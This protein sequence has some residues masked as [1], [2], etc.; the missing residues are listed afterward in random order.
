MNDEAP[1]YDNTPVIPGTRYRV[2]DRTRPQPLVVDPPAPGTQRESGTHPSDAT[3]LFDGTDLSP[4]EGANGEAPQWKVE[5]GYMEVVPGTGN[6]RTRQ[7]FGDGQWHIE[8]A[9]PSEIESQSQGRGN[10]G[11]FLMG[12]YEVQVLDSYENP[13]YADGSAGAI[14]GQTPPLVNACRKP[15]E[16][17][18]FDIIWIAPRF[19]GEEVLTPARITVL[20]NGLL[21]HHDKEL[22]GPTTHKD[23]RPY[24]AHPETGPLV[25]QDHNN[26]VKFRNIW[27][28]AF[29]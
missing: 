27:W 24:T 14:Y 10:S 13:T 1:G 11:V 18:T 5:N 4:W 19:D 6:I 28:R 16:W 2:H 23:V 21:I 8:W 20:H 25:L 3:L 17:Q 7:H 29:A 15:G 12:Q 26:P 9:A 22:I